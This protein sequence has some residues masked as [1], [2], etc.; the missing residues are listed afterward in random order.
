VTAEPQAAVE[1]E[2]AK[3]VSV[4]QALAAAPAPAAAGVEAA[5]DAAG[6]IWVNTDADKLRAA[7]EAAAQV[8]PQARAPR[9]RK[10]LPPV[11]STPMQQ[12]ETG[13][14]H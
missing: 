11:D 7:Q 12:V 9:E 13:S 5:L 10:A 4:P 14:R 1:P 6:L 3:P 2:P 8:V